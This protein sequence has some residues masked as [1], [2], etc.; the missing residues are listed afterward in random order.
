[1]HRTHFVPRA[2]WWSLLLGCTLH[3]AALAAQGPGPESLPQLP[4]AP[5]FGQP[6]PQ[7]NQGQPSLPPAPLT[8]VPLQQAPAIQ[9][10]A[11]QPAAQPGDKGEAPPLLILPT[12]ETRELRMSSNQIIAEARSENPKVARIQ[13]SS[14]EPRAVLVTGQAAGTTRIFLTDVK[15]NTEVLEVRVLPDEAVQREQ[16][17][18]ELL[19]QLRRVVPTAAVEVTA[20]PNNTVVLSGVVSR[21]DDVQTITDMTRGIFGQ[22][23]NINNAMR[24]GGVQQVQL[25]VV[26][27]VVNRSE[28]RNMDFNFFINRRT[29]FLDSFLSPFSSLNSVA[30]GIAGGASNAT[31]SGGNLAFGVIKDQNGIAGVLQALR[32]EGLAKILSQPTV[33]TLSGRPAFIVSGGEVPVL[34]STGVGAPNVSYKQFGTVVNFLPIVLGNGKIHL[35]VRPELSQRNDANN[36]TIAGT[37]PTVIPGFDLRSAQVAVQMEDGQTLAIGGLINHTVNSSIRRVPFLGDLP[38]VGTMFSTKSYDE[39][40]EEMIILVTPR[41]VDPMACC[42]L[43]RYLPGQETR[44]PDDFEFY[45]EGILEAPRGPRHCGPGTGHHYRAAYL[46]DPTASAYPCNDMSRCGHGYHVIGNHGSYC[47]PN[48]CANG[49]CPS[50]V[51]NNGP[52]SSG[53]YQSGAMVIE[54]GPMMEVPATPTIR[55]VTGGLT[56]DNNGSNSNG[57]SNSSTV[58]SGI[59]GGA[60]VSQGGMTSGSRAVVISPAAL[61]AP[62]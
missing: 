38:F 37:T 35:E 2:F 10:V 21:A 19:E 54:S 44:S 60:G 29:F 57:T 58:N 26:V 55:D 40:E 43:P 25:E 46:N 50:P 42:Q 7:P 5:G 62:R 4:A 18:K 11:A 31:A 1:M 20:L 15:K 49:S 8:Q 17:R 45:L 59:T 12:G 52:V 33:M 32:T 27:A 39:R 14:L 24:I 3:H 34:L 56:V 51:V 48:G 36:V 30:V 22:A 9:Q 61:S 41:L 53:V 16:Q 47:G 6:F 13:A 28:V 23:A